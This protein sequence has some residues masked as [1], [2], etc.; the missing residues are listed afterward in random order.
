[1]YESS[2]VYLIFH[3]H[4]Q[5]FLHITFETPFLLYMYLFILTRFHHFGEIETLPS[6]AAAAPQTKVRFHVWFSCNKQSST[7][8]ALMV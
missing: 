7:T 8:G 1:M 2:K 4:H 5:S 6:L 3:Y